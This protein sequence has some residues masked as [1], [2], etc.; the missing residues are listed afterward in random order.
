VRPSSVY[1]GKGDGERF[2]ADRLR[3]GN[4]KV[5]KMEKIGYRIRAWGA[6]LLM[7][8]LLGAA[9][10]IAGCATTGS[11]RETGKT[12]WQ[13]SDQYVKIEKQDSL[14]DVEV[15]ANCHPIDISVGRLR[16]MLDSIKVRSSEEGKPTE[17]FT[18]DELKTLSAQI[19]TGLVSAGP[20][21]DITFATIGHHAALA[22]LLKQ[23]MI[24]LG[25]VFCQGGEINIIFGDVLREVNEKEDRRLHPYLQ[26]MR[27]GG[28][29]RQFELALVQGKE[30]FIMKRPDWVIFPVAGPVSTVIGPAAPAHGESV[31]MQTRGGQPETPGGKPATAGKGSIEERL[32]LLNDLK[33]RKLI[34]DEEYRAKRREILNEL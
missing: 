25:R 16:N 1:D 8:V 3:V 6:H 9:V 32:I 12:V 14:P 7:V 22:G 5:T 24:T 21:E 15:K 19:H 28:G 23:R 11:A 20:D 29:G 2:L 34:T 33:N 30:K 27:K 10:V 18:D 4:P 31:D 17:L 13:Q 26:G